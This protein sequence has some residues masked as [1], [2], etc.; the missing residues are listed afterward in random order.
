MP[1]K[2]YSSRNTREVGSAKKKVKF[3]LFCF[4]FSHLEHTVCQEEDNIE[5]HKEQIL[6]QFKIVLRTVSAIS[7]SWHKRQKYFLVS[8]SK[9]LNSCKENVPFNKEKYL[10][11]NVIRKKFQSNSQQSQMSYK[12][13]GERFLAKSNSCLLPRWQIPYLP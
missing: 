11:S 6:M 1:G 8:S 9:L 7:H 3:L 2:C 12:N 4:F 13:R 10:C 5:H